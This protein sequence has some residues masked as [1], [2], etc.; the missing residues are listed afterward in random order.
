MIRKKTQ[1]QFVI[2]FIHCHTWNLKSVT[3]A[4]G[5][6]F[7][8]ALS[9][10]R[11]RSHLVVHICTCYRQTSH[12]S[13][14]CDAFSLRFFQI[15]KSFLFTCEFCGFLWFFLFLCFGPFSFSSSTNNEFCFSCVVRKNIQKPLLF[16]LKLISIEHK[17]PNLKCDTF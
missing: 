14:V 17:D 11:M 6:N 16:R 13:T 3:L 10:I 12:Y 15:S 9:G 8:I 5:L 1:F 4:K 2:S 7:P